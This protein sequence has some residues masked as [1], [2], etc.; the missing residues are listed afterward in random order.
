MVLADSV[1]VSCWIVLFIAE[2]QLHI[3]PFQL[4]CM[5]YS[6][7]PPWIRYLVA[8]GLILPSWV[9]SGGYGLTA[10]SCVLLLTALFFLLLANVSLAISVS[11]GCC[12]YCN[13]KETCHISLQT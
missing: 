9:C 8:E 11:C 10:L 7:K 3:F 5:K 4:L 13:R 1:H 6:L 12:G 2:L